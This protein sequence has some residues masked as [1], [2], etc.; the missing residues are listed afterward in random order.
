M[1]RQIE[2]ETEGQIDFDE[3][4]KVPKNGTRASTRFVPS[5]LMERMVPLL[6]LILAAALVGTLLLVILSSVKP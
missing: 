5:K 4:N 3:T 6:L 2:K 1:N